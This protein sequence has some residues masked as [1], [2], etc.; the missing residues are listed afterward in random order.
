M[1]FIFAFIVVLSL[2]FGAKAD[3]TQTL[4]QKL[5]LAQKYADLMPVDEQIVSTI[6][7]LAVQIPLDQRTV[8]RSIMERT[9]KVDRLESVSQMALVEIFSV[10]ELEAL[11]G[12]YSTKE[13][14]SVN[15]KMTD[16]QEAIRPVLE[17]MVRESVQL[18]HNQTK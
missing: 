2:G 9:I 17:Q 13:G 6:D 16:Y 11:V 4:A 3:E 8:F 1:H 5:T 18:F 14:Q 15:R 10:E 7:A 12:F